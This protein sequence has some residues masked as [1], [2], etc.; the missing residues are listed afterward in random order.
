M[1]GFGADDRFGVNAKTAGDV[2]GDGFDDFIIGGFLNDG[3]GTDAG[4]AYLY[5]GGINVNTQPDVV[6]SGHSTNEY[7]G[8]AVST[9]GDVNGDGYSDVTVSTFGD[10]VTELCIYISAVLQ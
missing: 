8:A 6:F 7:F 9:A 1:T 2:N 5:Y 4:R 3:A 10:G